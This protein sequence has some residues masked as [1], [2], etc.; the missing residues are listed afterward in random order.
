MIHELSLG[1][2]DFLSHCGMGI[3]AL[4]LTDMLASEGLASTSRLHFP[5]RAKHVIHIFLNG[6][7]SQ[8]DTFDPKP[9]LTKRGGQMLPFDNLQTERKTG[10]AFP[11]PFAFQKHGQSEIGRAHV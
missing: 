8:V 9:E 5:G 4:A 11:S 6:G 1:R 3:G 2:R 10:V 7:M